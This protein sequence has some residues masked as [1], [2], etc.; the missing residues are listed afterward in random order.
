MKK[1]SIMFVICAG[2]VYGKE[3]KLQLGV[4][5]FRYTTITE[6]SVTEKESGN[7][8]FSIGSEILWD[9]KNISYGLGFEVKNEIKHSNDFF[10]KHSSYFS[11]PIYGVINY[12]VANSYYLL[13]RAGI[14][15]TTGDIVDNGGLY[16]GV[17]VGKTFGNIG[18]E[19]I[20]ETSQ[21]KKNGDVIVINNKINNSGLFF[22]GALDEISLKISYLFGKGNSIKEIP[23]KNE[24][25]EP[26][27]VEEIKIPVI[28]EVI[29]NIIIEEKVESPIII[30]EK[31]NENN[32]VETVVSPSVILEDAK[33]VI[34]NQIITEKPEI[35]NEEKPKA[36]ATE[37]I[38]VV[39]AVAVNSTVIE[40][41]VK[42]LLNN[43]QIKEEISFPPIQGY[44]TNTIKLTKEQKNL[45]N[46]I[47]KDLEGKKGT[48]YVIGYTDDTGSEKYNLKISQKRADVVSQTI[49]NLLENS[50]EILIKPIG[51]G[52]TNFIVKNSS[53]KN[54]KM[55]IRVEFEFSAE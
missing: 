31:I 13:G 42:E 53:S 41:Q 16:L 25:S 10:S 44:K 9:K 48:L 33:P 17:G 34:E 49:K 6:G 27:K 47:A 5:P 24:V 4:T 46:G 54:R 55:N 7:L 26:L 45:V 21:L 39:E 30:E 32:S 19:L 11:S 15:Y 18:A 29:Q 51:K 14:V 3:Y 28:K 8:G 43:E 2:L 35:I 12:S 20:Y 22:N 40:N 36:E 50:K 52:E 37:T 38:S 23:V 1:L